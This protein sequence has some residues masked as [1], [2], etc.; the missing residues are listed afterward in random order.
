MAEGSGTKITIILQG[1]NL[2]VR[3]QSCDHPPTVMEVRTYRLV[4]YQLSGY[5]LITANF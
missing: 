5:Y 2:T 4:E 1:E 3:V